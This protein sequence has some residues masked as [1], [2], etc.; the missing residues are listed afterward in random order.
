MAETYTAQEYALGYPDGIET[1]FWH[2]ARHHAL[3]R[4]LKTLR[5]K[6]QLILDVGCGV[7]ITT[8]F[9]HDQGFNIRGIEQGDAPVPEPSRT[10]ITTRQDLFDMTA[11]QKQDV[12]CVLLLDVLE[13]MADREGFLTELQRQLPNCQTLVLTVPARRELWGEFDRFWGHQLR[14]DRPTLAGEL[15]RCGFTVQRISYYFHLVYLAG[16]LLKTLRVN[17]SKAFSSPRKS[18]PLSLLHR[19]LGLYGRLENRLIPG[20]IPGSSILCVATRS[21]C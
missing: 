19:L 14:Y 6:D 11:A 13:H 8:R 12:T 9:L 2:I 17:R 16:L 21:P 1:H 3:L 15:S 4:A 5:I 20:F 10:Y 18:W 7:G